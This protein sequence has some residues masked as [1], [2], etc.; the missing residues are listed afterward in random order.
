MLFHPPPI[1]LPSPWNCTELLVLWRSFGHTQ[2]PR[3]ARGT[4]QNRFYKTQPRSRAARASS[5]SANSLAL[6]TAADALLA[7]AL[8]AVVREAVLAP[9]PPVP[10][11]L[12][13][14]DFESV[15]AAAG[16]GAA[17]EDDAADAATAEAEADAAAV[18]A[19]AGGA[20]ALSVLASSLMPSFR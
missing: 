15:C 19:G 17:A 1:P 18:A 20:G 14:A 11:S 2:T 16:A 7:L 4:E 9:E 8:L 6:L 3:R 5:E 10:A 13:A 12:V